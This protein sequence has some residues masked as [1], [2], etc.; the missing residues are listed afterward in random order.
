MTAQKFRGRRAAAAAA[1]AVMALGAT[2]CAAINQ[3]AT[4][5]QYDASDGVGFSVGG[6]QARNMLLVSGGENEQA[7]I[8]GTLLNETQEQRQVTFE[9]EGASVNVS[10]PADTAL[11]LEDDAN[12]TIVPSP[13]DAPGS[14]SDVTVS[15]GQASL[16]EQIPVVDGTLPE[17]R[18]FVPS[19]FEESN[20]AHLHESTKEEAGQW[21]RGA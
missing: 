17:Y 10:V 12:R 11:K 15:S 21:A 5:L 6:L 16:Q 3:Q 20:I 13:G 7:R 4:T 8:I 1:L 2:G 9:V 18:P 14:M 19:G